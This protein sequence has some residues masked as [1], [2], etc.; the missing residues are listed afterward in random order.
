MY[1]DES[2]CWPPSPT[3]IMATWSV[4]AFLYDASSKD[5]F[6]PRIATRAKQRLPLVPKPHV[7]VALFWKIA[8]GWFRNLSQWFLNNVG[9][10]SSTLV[11][12][13]WGNW[14]HLKTTYRN[15]CHVHIDDFKGSFPLHDI[16][17]KSSPTALKPSGLPGTWVNS[18]ILQTG[19]WHNSQLV[20]RQNPPPR[21]LPYFGKVAKNVIPGTRNYRM[22]IMRIPTMCLNKNEY[23]IWLDNAI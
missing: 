18:S 2:L 16:G 10:P 6:I 23:I 9:G 20:W 12:R 4:A 7:R 19:W 15:A 17:E 8:S 11:L 5:L 3:G 13:G 21:E 22:M 14:K 1:L